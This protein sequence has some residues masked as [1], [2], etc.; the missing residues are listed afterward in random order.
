MIAK[1]FWN[2]E[3]RRLRAVWRLVLQLLLFAMLTST[4]YDLF[5]YAI[6]SALVKANDPAVLQND[7]AALEAA[8][9]RLYSEQPFLATLSGV[10]PLAGALLSV[11]IAARLFDRRRLRE[12][13]LRFNARWLMDLLAGL[14]IGALTAGLLFGVEWL[15]GWVKIGGTQVLS[16]NTGVT[17]WT[18][19]AVNLVFLL[20]AALYESLLT[21]GYQ[22][23][24]LGEAFNAPHMGAKNALWMA[25]II[26]AAIFG[27]STTPAEQGS[28]F[29]S[30]VNPVLTGLFFGLGM[31]LT[32]QLGLTIGLNLGWNVFAG[33]VFGFAVNAQPP[34]ASL[35]GIQAG[36]PEWLTGGALGPG[37]GVILIPTLL[38]GA[39][40]VV[41]Y[42]RLT[43]GRVEPQEEL[44][45]Y[46]PP[47]TPVV[48]K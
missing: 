41:G 44:A 48:V 27:V 29:L 47:E 26:A 36:G 35:L 11:W 15:A 42:V 10:A 24:N 45:V 12:Y 2:A 21:S 3:E 9:M 25:V 16:Q 30:A 32:G 5:G 31:L 38:A 34:A 14:G 20:C 1:W 4:V 43:R 13:G 6:Q 37:L 17:F 40:L 22:L 23:R 33:L 7:S 28:A 18:V 46:T 8:V 39:A 19:M